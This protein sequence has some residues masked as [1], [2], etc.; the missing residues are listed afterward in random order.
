MWYCQ[1]RSQNKG[2]SDQYIMTIVCSDTKIH[3]FIYWR[4]WV[5]GL[6]CLMPLLTIFSVISW[7]SVFLVEET[8]VL[9]KNHLQVTDKLHHIML[10]WLSRISTEY[11]QGKDICTCN[12]SRWVMGAF[13]MVESSKIFVDFISSMHV[14]ES[15]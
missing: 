6:W 1:K 7:R 5:Y 3:K 15:Y 12:S 9:S 4:G 8:G 2:Q 11:N 14:F 10:Y 13:R